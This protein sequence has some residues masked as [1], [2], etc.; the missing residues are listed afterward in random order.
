MV[1]KY[2]GLKTQ[3]KHTLPNLS[4]GIENLF[5]KFNKKLIIKNINNPE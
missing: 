5:Y 4:I 3:H 1:S 2:S